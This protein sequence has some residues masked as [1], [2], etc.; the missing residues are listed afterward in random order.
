[1]ATT[2]D[3]PELLDQESLQETRPP[4]VGRRRGAI[5]LAV[6]AAIYLVLSVREFWAAW[7]HD[8]SSW[9]QLAG[10]NDPGQA[11]FFMAQTPAALLHG[12]N[13]IS[14]SLEP[15]WLAMA[16]VPVFL[17]IFGIFLLTAVMHG[18]RA[19]GRLQAR[20]AKRLLV[21]AT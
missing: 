18:A 12:L 3:Y 13:L 6:V 11:V 19:I 1:M 10:A 8:P 5:A 14:A 9:L 15:A 17:G 16:P 7:S 2:H 21:T 4:A 20:V